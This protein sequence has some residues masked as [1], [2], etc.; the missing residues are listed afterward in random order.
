MRVQGICHSSCIRTPRT[1]K[2]PCFIVTTIV[3]HLISNLVQVPYMDF[4]QPA[5]LC[6]GIYSE[7]YLYLG[8]CAWNADVWS[9]QLDINIHT[10]MYY[11][12]ERP[13]NKRTLYC[14]Y[15]STSTYTT[16]A[17]FSA[18]FEVCRDIHIMSKSVQCNVFSKTLLSLYSELFFY[19]IGI[20]TFQSD[21]YFCSSVYFTIRPTF[22]KAYLQRICMSTWHS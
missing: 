21:Y 16:L 20:S 18:A 3:T 11:T 15:T 1:T 22:A 2:P 13:N 19:N 7:K 6:S 9:A 14:T 4:I 17:M 12:Y 5:I 8:A 10:T